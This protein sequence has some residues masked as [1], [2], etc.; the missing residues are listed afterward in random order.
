MFFSAIELNLL[1]ADTEV[2]PRAKENA[3]A[4]V[5]F[6]LQEV[7]IGRRKFRSGT[8][9][10]AVQLRG[11]PRVGLAPQRLPRYETSLCGKIM[12]GNKRFSFETSEFD[13]SAQN[14]NK[15]LRR[16]NIDPSEVTPTFLEVSLA[17]LQSPL[18][19]FQAKFEDIQSMQCQ[20]LHD[21]WELVLNLNKPLFCYTKTNG[22]WQT[23]ESPVGSAK[24]LRCVTSAPS[25][26]QVAWKLWVKRT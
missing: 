16:K 4:P 11:D 12:F 6:N 25:N 19:S 9:G 8:S 20:K 1:Q 7:Q 15:I 17:K 26:D 5:Q 10:P 13:R 14:I 22:S 2:M 3:P 23:V 21:E 18:Y 24:T